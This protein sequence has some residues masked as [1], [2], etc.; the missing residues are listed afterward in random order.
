MPAIMLRSVTLAVLA[1]TAVASAQERARPNILFAIADDWSYGHAGAY[2]AAW[3]RTPTFDRVAAEGLVFTRA[4]TPNAKCAPS[5]AAIL[6]GRNS[7]QLDAAANHNAF[8][9]PRFGGFMEA[10]AAGGYATGFT[11]KGWGPGVARLHDGSPRAITGRRFATAKAAPPTRGIADLDYAANFAAFLAQVDEGA[12]WA[13]WYGA[14]EPHRGYEAGSG[15]RAGKDPADIARVPGYWPDV[16]DVRSD[17]LDYAVEVEHFDAHLGRMLAQL[18]TAGL[19]DDTLVIVTS[20]HGM[21]FPRVKGQAYDAAN[22]VPFAVRWP[23]EIATPG[24]IVD[25]FVSLIDVAPTLLEVAGLLEA[26]A[27]MAAIT[28]RSLLG[29]FRAAP[30]AR[31]PPHRD[32]VLIGKER[33]DVGRPQDQGYPIRGIVRGEWLYLHNC[34][35]DRWPAGNPETG[36]LNC[37][38][39]P[40]K[41]LILERRRAAGTDPFW[42]SCFGLRPAEE[43]YHLGADPDCLVNL[44]ARATFA[45]RL[46]SLRVELDERLAAEG[47]PRARGEGHVFDAY[48]VAPANQRRFYERFMAGE[49]LRAGWVLKSDF[50]PEPLPIK[51]EV[52]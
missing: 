32:H 14:F 39:S 47:D 9:P 24:R 7:W 41:T 20:D 49:E 27:G 22:H 26:P 48:P 43:L 17:L 8:F 23:R 28:G 30:D 11:G 42:E 13:F 31:A 44:A 29:V 18:E 34:E 3:V 52:R 21:P 5:R 37:D 16:E 33:H 45:E 35:P 15:V 6:T 46:A 10:L 19:L 38:A 2:G 25:D 51:R 12:P 40:T 36:Y 4:Y 1:W 50:E